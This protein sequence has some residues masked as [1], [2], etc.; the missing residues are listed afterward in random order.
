MKTLY[1]LGEKDYFSIGHVRDFACKYACPN[2][3]VAETFFDAF[4][5]LF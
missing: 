4:F 1:T 2:I 5:L 3:S